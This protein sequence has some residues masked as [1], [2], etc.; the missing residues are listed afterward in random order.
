MWCSGVVEWLCCIVV[1]IMMVLGLGRA[2]CCW[3]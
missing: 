1:V 2:S 3:S